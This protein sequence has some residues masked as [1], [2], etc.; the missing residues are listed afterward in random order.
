MIKDHFTTKPKIQNKANTYPKGSEIQL[1]KVQKT[2]EQ[3][4]FLKLDHYE[5]SYNEFT[6]MAHLSRP[7][8]ALKALHHFLGQSH[9][10]SFD[11]I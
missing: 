2:E 1:E 11:L 7:V 3:L 10:L 5:S 8:S 6:L 9:V 4:R